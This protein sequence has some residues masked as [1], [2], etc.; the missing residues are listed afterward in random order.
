MKNSELGFV[1]QCK[2]KDELR[3]LENALNISKDEYA[4]MFGYFRAIYSA[5]DKPKKRKPKEGESEE[6]ECKAKVPEKQESYIKEQRFPI[7]EEFAEK[8]CE[9]ITNRIATIKKQLNE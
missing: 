9:Y 5:D 8:M 6:K 4:E 3:V 1:E 2:L 7:S